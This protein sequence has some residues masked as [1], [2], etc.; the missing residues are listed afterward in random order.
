[1]SNITLG[2]AEYDLL[3]KS[4]ETVSAKIDKIFEKINHMDNKTVALEEWR[5][6]HDGQTAVH[7]SEIAGLKK[8]VATLENYRW[9][10]VGISV[11]ISGLI[12]IVGVLLSK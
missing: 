1:M 8:R 4:I 9:F 3:I 12:A 7:V 10:L 2:A 6:H 5:K 11:T